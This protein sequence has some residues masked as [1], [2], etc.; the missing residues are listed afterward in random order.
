MSDGFGIEFHV[1]SVVDKDTVA[2]LEFT[3][4]L[5]V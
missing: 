3:T 4:L 1:G 2:E 5:I